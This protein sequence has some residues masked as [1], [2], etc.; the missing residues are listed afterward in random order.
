MLRY[1]LRA[2]GFAV[3]LLSIQ[4][5]GFAADTDVRAAREREMLRRT[6]EALRQS[7]AEN[8]ELVAQKATAEKQADEKLQAAA[9]QLDST[10]KASRSTQAALQAQLQ[11]AV[12]KQA[13]LTTLLA[14]ANR[15]LSVIAGK[16]QQTAGELKHS[17]EQLEASKESNSACEAKNLQ[18]YR[19]SQELMTRYEKKGVWAALEQK[20]PFSGVKEVRIENVLQEYQTKLEAEKIKPAAQ[21]LK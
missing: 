17:Q 11:S 5:S 8:A 19:Y 1:A 4:G 2:V 13:E 20:E 6:Q 9:A 14:D 3:L 10:R 12:S 15:Q 21:P 18:L 7:Q 16:Q